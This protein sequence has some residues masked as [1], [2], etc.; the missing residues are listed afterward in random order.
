M[1]QVF[2]SIRVI[3][4]GLPPPREIVVGPTSNPRIGTSDPIE[5]PPKRETMEFRFSF[6][7]TNLR[8]YLARNPSGNG[9][10]YTVTKDSASTR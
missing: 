5:M 8:A 3:R 10:A 1:V 9:R 6:I 7:K 4:I 2:A